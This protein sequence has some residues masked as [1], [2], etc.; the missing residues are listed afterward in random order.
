MLGKKMGAF[1]R[2]S[3]ILLSLTVFVVFSL[4]WSRLSLAQASVS[5]GQ[6]LSGEIAAV[7]ETDTF[8]FDAQANDAVSITVAKVTTTG[9]SFTPLW[10]WGS[11]IPSAHS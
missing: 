2:V 10:V 5:C 1:R 3:T 11:E 4:Q 8:T 6:T 7:D 9:G